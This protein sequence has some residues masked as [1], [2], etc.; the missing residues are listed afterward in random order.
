M[1][2]F[3]WAVRISEPY[4]DD[5]AM[6]PAGPPLVLSCGRDPELPDAAESALGARDPLPSQSASFA[7]MHD[8]MSCLALISWGVRMPPARVKS[9]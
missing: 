1:F 6:T 9:T 4:S 2:L 3:A 5:A 7:Y 8:I